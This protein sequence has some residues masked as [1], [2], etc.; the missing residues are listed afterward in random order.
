MD[1]NWE[2]IDQY[3]EELAEKIKKSNYQCDA[4]IGIASGGL[5][6]TTYLSKLLGIKKIGLFC[7]KSYCDQTQCSLEIISRPQIDLEN[8]S[9][10]LVDDLVDTGITVKRI[11]Q[12]LVAEYN[13]KEV[14]VVAYFVNKEHCNEYPEF[15]VKENEGWVVFPW[16]LKEN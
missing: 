14:R 5:I 16:E 10:L 3:S 4:I 8:K 9:V 13:V 6:P 7:A 1:V 2:Q 12:I 11:K 15:Y